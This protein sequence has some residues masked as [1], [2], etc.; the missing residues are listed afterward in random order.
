MKNNINILDNNIYKYINDS[1][2]LI[3]DFLMI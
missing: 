2:N 3:F 1:H